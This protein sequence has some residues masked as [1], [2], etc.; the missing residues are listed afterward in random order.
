MQL[1]VKTRARGL[2]AAVILGFAAVAVGVA[3]LGLASCG[4]ADKLSD[5][6]A[7]TWAAAPERL[8]IVGADAATLTRVMEFVGQD[9]TPDGTVTLT[10]LI[11]VDNTVASSSSSDDDAA[12]TATPES[13][14]AAGDDT[15]PLSFTA[16]GSV[17]IT[18]AFQAQNGHEIDLRLDRSSLTVQLDPSAIEMRLNLDGGTAKGVVEKLRPGAAILAR[19]QITR[20]ANRQFF[21]LDEID[22]I[23]ISGDLLTCEVKGADLTFRRQK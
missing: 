23:R 17:T 14:T 10:A 3:G 19:Q 7:G 1:N 5:E 16:T 4:S 13:V 22:E 2:A 18:G 9:D 20:A 11:T 15:A 21:G 8:D 12:P 6:I